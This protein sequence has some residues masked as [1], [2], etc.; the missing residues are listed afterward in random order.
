MAK[1]ITFFSKLSSAIANATFFIKNA[2]FDEISSRVIL[3]NTAEPESGVQINNLQRYVNEIAETSGITEADPDRLNY[4]SNNFIT[5]G[6]TQK[7]CIEDL[8]EQVGLNADDIIDRLTR[9]ANDYVDFDEKISPV[10]DDYVL[11]EDSQDSFSKKKLKLENMIGN[12]VGFGENASGIVNGLNKDFTIT[13]AP[14]DENSII[15]FVNGNCIE[16]NFSYV[17]SVI[18]LTDAPV[19]GQSVFVWYLTDGSPSSPVVISG[20]ENVDYVT[21]TALMITNKQLT[22]L[23]TPAI[24]VNTKVDVIGGSAQYYGVDFTV[25]GNVLSWNGLGLDGEIIENDVLRIGYFS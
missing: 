18:T 17:G 13:K 14:T 6:N 10:I 22:L 8:D 25:S 4:I 11:I 1:G 3:K 20:T 23:N 7:E 21:I 5:D 24:S 16:G 9:L 19:L 15:V 2:D 12:S